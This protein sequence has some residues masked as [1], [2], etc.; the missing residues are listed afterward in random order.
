M[1]R[2]ATAFLWLLAPGMLGAQDALTLTEE[3]LLAAVTRDHPAAVALRDERERTAA[4]VARA[5]LLPN[6]ALEAS[7]E[8]PDEASRETAALLTWAPFDPRR[9]L[10]REVAARGLAAAESRL[11][12]AG[13]ALRLELRAAYT[14]WAFAWERRGLLAGHLGRVSELARSAHARAQAGE[15]AGLA[16]RRFA[17]EEAQAGADLGRA[18]ADLAAARA[19]VAAW[20]PD[21]PAGARPA[22]PLL[23]SAP[24]GGPDLA[25][26]PDILTRELEIERAEALVRLS[27]R[28]AEAPV[29]GL[30]WKRIEDEVGSASGPMAWVGWTL[31]LFDRRQADRREAEARLA[32]ARAELALARSRGEAGQAA[33]LAA[34]E[35]LRSEAE[36]ITQTASSTEEVAD[37]ATAAYRLG[38][39]SLTDF[40]DTLRAALAMRIAVLELRDAALTAHRD[41]EAAYGRPLT[42][43]SGDQP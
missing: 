1:H 37:G 31:P 19:E 17:Y 13:L 32:T 5:A 43:N 3:G 23:P 38:E 40:L 16:A 10:R 39:S 18:E 34:Y 8:E 4:E 26:H 42:P 11:G 15:I 20:Y 29:L 22:A 27:R 7:F 28:F 9:S 14:G 2:S 35:R 41:L 21:L 36:R 25:R 12:A 30:G 6:P 33:S 24:E